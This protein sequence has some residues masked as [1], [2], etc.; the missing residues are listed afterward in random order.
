MGTV[1]HKLATVHE[2]AQIGEDCSIGAFC[3]V[4]PNV[5][6]GNGTTLVSHVVVDGHTRIGQNCK[7]YPFATIGLQSQDLKYN[8][9]DV[10]Y[11]V[12]GD[13]N[14][15]REH[16][17]IH[18]ATEAGTTTSIGSNC[19]ILAQAHVGHNCEVGDNVILSHAAT[20]GGHVIVQ[21]RANLGGLC[22][23]HQFCTIGAYS[24]IGGLSAVAKDVLPYSI[25]N[26]NPAIYRGVNKI[27][28]ERGDLSIDTIDEIQEVFKI[29]YLR[30]NLWA[31]ALELVERKFGDKP[32]IR[33]LLDVI[34][35]SSRGICSRE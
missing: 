21:D 22:A 11:C 31:D 26:G 18:S 27:G 15:I 34:A 19:A 12:I 1:I 16:V 8:E 32:H 4:G 28:M 35:D 14:I 10:T 7:I 23:V 30:D 29:L 6:I 20:L 24:M 17:S 5:S 33:T 3:N 25:V 2:N 13:N 9:D